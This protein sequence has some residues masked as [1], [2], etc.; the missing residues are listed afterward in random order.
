MAT[1]PKPYPG[2]KFGGV[3]RWFEAKCEC[4]WRGGMHGGTGG[5]SQA[6]TEFSW[7]IVACKKADGH[8]DPYATVKTKQY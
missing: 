7:H 1:R 3:Q 2:H 6:H 8:P 4:G 5:L